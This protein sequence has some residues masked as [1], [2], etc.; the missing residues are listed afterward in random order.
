MQMKILPSDIRF[1]LHDITPLGKIA[2]YG[3][4]IK[5]D[6]SNFLEGKGVK[7]GVFI[8]RKKPS[9]ISYE[10]L[11]FAQNLF[12]HV[13]LGAQVS[14]MPFKSLCDRSQALVSGEK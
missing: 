11:L 13:Q 14:N 9:Y 5:V 4:M 2:S 1:R 10:V 7:K 6:K 12:V 8:S 3:E